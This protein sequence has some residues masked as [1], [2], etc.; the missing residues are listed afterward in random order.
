MLQRLKTLVQ[1]I[2]VSILSLVHSTSEGGIP[3]AQ[4]YA[5]NNAKVVDRSKKITPTSKKKR[6]D[7][8]PANGATWFLSGCADNSPTGTGGP[9]CFIGAGYFK[10]GCNAE[11]DK[12]CDHEDEGTSPLEVYLDSFY[13]DKHEVTVR[14]YMDCV[15]DGVCKSDGLN[16]ED[17]EKEKK[18][19]LCNWNTERENH[20]INCVPWQYA[21]DYCA[22]AGKR[23]PTEAEWE[24]GARGGDAIIYP[25]GNDGYSVLGTNPKANI[26]DE[27]AKAKDSNGVKFWAKNYYDKYA[28]TSPVESFRTGRSPFGVLDMIGNVWE[29]TSDWYAE[30]I[31]VVTIDS[32]IIPVVPNKGSYRV[33]KGGSWRSRPRYARVSQRHRLTTIEQSAALGFRCAVS[34]SEKSKILQ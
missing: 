5:S 20:P 12:E 34:P 25:W 2:S 28:E 16:Y 8:T 17:K 14:E 30:Q 6:K 18:S 9:M 21:V 13:L 3:S 22:W 32:K 1:I 10:M 23:L 4:L 31:K 27:A 19:E 33:V 24:K 11:V 29:W 26:C 7:E 15:E